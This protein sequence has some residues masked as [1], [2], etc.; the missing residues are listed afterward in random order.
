MALYYDLP[1]FKDVYKLVL[2]VFDYT[3]DFPRE[4]RYT[5]GQDMKKDSIQLVRSIYRANKAKE[6]QVEDVKAE[7]A[8]FWLDDINSHNIRLT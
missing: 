6:K 8:K 1:V 3:K 5:L 2:K 4:Y 7:V